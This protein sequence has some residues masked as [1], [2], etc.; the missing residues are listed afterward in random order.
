MAERATTRRHWRIG[1]LAEATGLT[2]RTLH[3]YERVGLLAPPTRTEGRQRLY[4]EHDVRRLYRIRALRDLGLS[5]AN[6]A[7]ML[8]DDSVTLGDVLRAHLTH[9]DAELE[10]LGRLRTLLDRACT[11][12]ERGVEPDDALAA[13]EAM[14]RVV[15]RIDARATKGRA[16]DD[17]EARWRELA[18]ELRACMDAGHEPSSPRAHA[19][20]RAARAR[21]LD[22]ANNDQATLD[23]LA[24][25]RKL[26][27]PKTLAGWDSALLRY[28][29]R[30]LASL[31]EKE[32]DPC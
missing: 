28:L 23:A 15:R 4:D 5:L 11:Y 30:A 32:N 19:A 21:L 25:L 31:H 2:V 26:E 18:N 10:R 29:D 8:D 27:P 6:I 7:R 16:P 9:V 1:E 17:A 3:H 24:R 20:A 14:S 12:A 13:I 22:F